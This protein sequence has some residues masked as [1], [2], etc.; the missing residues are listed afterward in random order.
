MDVKMTPMI[1]V[2]FQL[3][4]FFVCTVS[5]QALEEILPADLR[6]AGGAASETKLDPELLELEEVVVR[7]EAPDGRTHWVLNGREYGDLATLRGV[8]TQLVQIRSDL[9]VILDV[10]PAIEM[11]DVIDAYDT[12]RLAGFDRIHFAAKTSN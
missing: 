10:D 5:F 12:C 11:G 2:V 6:A 9:T 7:V 4:I 8:L 3:L 1:D